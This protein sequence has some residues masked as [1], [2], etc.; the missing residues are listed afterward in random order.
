M[1]LHSVT[2]FLIASLNG[3][4]ALG[5]ASA[6]VPGSPLTLRNPL[7]RVCLINGGTFE[8]HPIGADEI[9]FCRWTR[10]VVDSQT[11]LSNLDGVQSE[12]AGLMMSDTIASTCIEVGAGSMILTTSVGQQ[13]LCDF[14][15]GS[16]L[17]LETIQADS[18][19]ADR[20]RLKDVI[21]GR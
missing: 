12:A 6:G 4:L 2:L 17:T 7:I 1:K 3:A 13:E 8:T 14:N 18:T 5:A 16:K 15:D 10:A 21:L 11:L 9:A 20:M 19:N